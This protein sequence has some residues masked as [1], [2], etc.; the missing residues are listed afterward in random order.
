ML[1]DHAGRQTQPPVS[2]ARPG[3]GALADRAKRAGGRGL[4]LLVDDGMDVIYG[5]DIGLVDVI[6]RPV[7]VEGADA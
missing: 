5:V 4:P 7:G 1:Y 6:R 3:G 2:A